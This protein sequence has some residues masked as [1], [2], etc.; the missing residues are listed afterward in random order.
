M[1]AP[2]F[3]EAMEASNPQLRAML[4]QLEANYDARLGRGHQVKPLS[5][6]VETFLRQMNRRFEQ[7]QPDGGS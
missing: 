2:G 1:A 6:E 5:A 3:I 4:A 7:G